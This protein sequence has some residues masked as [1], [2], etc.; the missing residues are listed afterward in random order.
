MRQSPSLEIHK[1]PLW[2]NP[3]NMQIVGSTVTFVTVSDKFEYA[4][5]DAIVVRYYP[6]K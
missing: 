3:A 6:K 1:E 4:G 2:V 5:A